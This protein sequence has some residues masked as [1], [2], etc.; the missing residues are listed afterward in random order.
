MDPSFR[1]SVFRAKEEERSPSLPLSRAAL[2]FEEEENS[3]EFSSLTLDFGSI[4]D[5]TSF[6]HSYKRVKKVWVEEVK[7]FEAL[8]N[9]V[10]PEFGYARS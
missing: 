9:Q 10:G 6:Y 8:Q 4:A 1:V 7:A 3:S 2:E 5:S